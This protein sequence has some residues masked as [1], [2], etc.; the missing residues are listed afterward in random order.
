MNT[1]QL[2]SL[3]FRHVLGA[4][5]GIAVGAGWADGETVT[6]LGGAIATIVAGVLSILEKRK[7]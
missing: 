1:G 4:A 2:I 5:G 3:I 7:R 6:G